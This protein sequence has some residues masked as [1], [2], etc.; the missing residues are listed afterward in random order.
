MD[1][2]KN[3]FQIFAFIK[4]AALLRRSWLSFDFKK[5]QELWFR[6]RKKKNQHKRYFI[7]GTY[8]Y[9]KTIETMET[10]LIVYFVLELRG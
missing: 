1:F 9:A 5:L 3:I 7:F 4:C 10:F 2:L 8:F 6:K